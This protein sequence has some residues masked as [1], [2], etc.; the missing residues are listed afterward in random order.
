MTIR[1]NILFGRPY[2]QARYE[3]VL[4][5]CQLQS[6]LD[7]FAGGDLTELGERGTNLSGGQ[8]ARISLARAVYADKPILL[9][10]DPISALD[11]NV[12]SKIFNE[13]FLTHLR[14]KTRIMVTHSID[15]LHVFD[16]IFLLQKGRLVQSGTYDEIKENPYLFKL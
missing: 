1:D 4:T 5:L 11:K 2:E 8:K 13:L 12:M 15:Y 3:K 9:M 10:D 14:D 7:S 6:D 16:R